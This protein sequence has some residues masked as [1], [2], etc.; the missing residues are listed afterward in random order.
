MRFRLLSLVAALVVAAGCSND[1]TAPAGRET[2]PEESLAQV[3]AT[4]TPEAAAMAAE[5][6]VMRGLHALP[7][8]LKLTR[9]QKATIRALLEAH[10]KA[11]QADLEQM[12][13]IRAAVEAARKAGAPPAEIAKLMEQGAAIAARVLE[14]LRTLEA[15]IL[16]VLTPAQRAWVESHAPQRCDRPRLT[17]A[18]KAQIRALEQAFVAANKADLDLVAA[19][20][21]EARAAHQAGKSR[22]EIS[23]ILQKA[24]A[25][26]ERLAKAQA[27]LRAQVAAIV[28]S[29]GIC[30]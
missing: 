3:L 17:D 10:A 30:R 8:S 9:E 7:D 1:T 14:S 11:R 23:A 12:K 20:M 29:A 13:A 2:A 22:A 16:D 6:P 25:A 4:T 27:E 5:A 19:V 21:A 18:Q 26:M 15:A 24:A 28:G